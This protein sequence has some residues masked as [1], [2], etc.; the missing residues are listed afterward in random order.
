MRTGAYWVIEF[1]RG[2]YQN[3]E[4]RPDIVTTLLPEAAEYDSEEEAQEVADLINEDLDEDDH[5]R[6]KKIDPDED[7]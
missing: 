6:V 3:W 1:E 7:D 5:C 4:K 2:T